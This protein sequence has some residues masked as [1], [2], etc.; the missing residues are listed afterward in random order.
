M[1]LSKINLPEGDLC[2]CIYPQKKSEVC[3][4]LDT[5]LSKPSCFYFKTSVSARFNDFTHC[6]EIHKCEECIKLHK[7]RR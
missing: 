2:G 7:I 1:E 6:I 4:G 5:K 3:F